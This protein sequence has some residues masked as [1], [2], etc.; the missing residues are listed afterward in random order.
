M[1]TPTLLILIAGVG[2]GLLFV[3]IGAVQLRGSSGVVGWRPLLYGVSVVALTVFL[4]FVY[5]TAF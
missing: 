5:L 3:L 2:F 4:T 1:D